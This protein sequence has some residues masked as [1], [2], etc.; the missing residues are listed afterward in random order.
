M[1]EFDDYWNSKEFIKNIFALYK[2]ALVKCFRKIY[3]WYIFSSKNKWYLSKNYNLY[4][5]VFRATVYLWEDGWNIARFNVHYKGYRSQNH[6]QQV[7]FKMW[8][9]D[10]K[11]LNKNELPK[12]LLKL[13]SL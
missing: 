4:N 11:I 1:R 10:R 7:A 9:N 3:V 12:K 13:P 2:K 5:P 6:A 8:L